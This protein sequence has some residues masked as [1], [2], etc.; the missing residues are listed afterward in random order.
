VTLAFGSGSALAG[1]RFALVRRRH[2]RVLPQRLPGVAGPRRRLR[3]PDP[4]SDQAFAH[5]VGLL[6]ASSSF[7]DQ[8]CPPSGPPC[9]CGSAGERGLR[10][11]DVDV[12][13][14]LTMSLVASGSSMI[15]KQLGVD[16][17]GL[18]SARSLTD[19]FLSRAG[20]RRRS[21]PRRAGSAIAGVAC[22]DRR[23]ARRRAP[24]TVRAR[25]AR[26][27]CCWSSRSRRPGGGWRRRS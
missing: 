21:R 15:R 10:S 9:C 11:E 14:G 27:A 5:C 7:Q 22:L 19:G 6:A 8:P 17:S 1:A 3:H 18:A 4:G 20:R 16:H 26:S 13:D 2:L 24:S 23:A 25:R 12:R